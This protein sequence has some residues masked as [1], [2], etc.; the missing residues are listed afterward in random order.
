MAHRVLGLMA[1]VLAAALAALPAVAADSPPAAEASI[2]V[3]HALS[4]LEGTEVR[5]PLV[6]GSDG[7]YYGAAREGGKHGRGSLFRVS[8]DGV[9]E[10]L[11]SFRGGTD[12]WLPTGL[13]RG[14]DGAFYGLTDAGGE[15]GLGTAFRIN[16]NGKHT[17][18]HSFQ[19]Q[20]DG[21]APSGTLLLASDGFFYGVTS[22]GGPSGG[23]TLFRLKRNG[24]VEVVHA[25]GGA[26]SVPYGRLLEGPDGLLYGTTAHGGKH[27][28]G[29]VFKMHRNGGLRVLHSF[30][31]NGS[32]GIWPDTGLTLGP[33]GL[34]YGVAKGDKLNRRGVIYRID[35]RGHFELLSTFERAGRDGREPEHEL[36]LGRDG[37][38][39]GT[40]QWG[41]EHFAGTV[42]RLGIDG[43]LEPVYAFDGDGPV[44]YWP[45]NT[46]LETA[47]GEFLGATN[48]KSDFSPGSIY[49][50][51]LAPPAAAGGR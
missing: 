18:L 2:E 28:G 43:S 45:A 41:G 23:G 6:V 5:G 27:G 36:L 20:V 10:V 19:G 39:Y 13:V 26:A 32:D 35:S 8:A 30:S 22:T 17:L 33:D 25:F 50:L 24:R 9:F 7:R 34:F 31:H 21:R 46:L 4:L 29:T 40:T 42:F 47:D 51:R 14:A 44:G 15:L 16:E 37:A 38:L 12:G 11:Y 1:T 3:V 48:I 49:R